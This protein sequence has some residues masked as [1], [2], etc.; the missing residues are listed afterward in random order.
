MRYGVLILAIFIVGVPTPNQKHRSAPPMPDH[1]V[2]ARDTF[3]DFG[4]PFDD[5]ELIFVRP[6]EDGSSIERVRLTPSWNECIDPGKVE[7][8]AASINKSP[9]ALLGATNPCAIPEKELTRELKRRKHGLVFSGAN[10]VLQ[11][12]C[13]DQLRQIK[14]DILDRDI[15]LASPDTPKHTSWTMKLLEQLDQAIGSRVVD[16]P[17]FPLNEKPEGV[18]HPESEPDSPTLQDV[19]KGKFDALFPGTTIKASEVYRAAQLLPPAPIV[20]LVGA[21]DVPPEAFSLPAYPMIA[22][23]TRTEGEVTFDF[24]IDHNGVPTNIRNDIGPTSLKSGV[25]SAIKSWKFP[26]DSAGRQVKVTFEFLLTCKP[27]NHY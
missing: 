24:D 26:K 12:Q 19:S 22:Q 1:F 4:P 18:Q 2:I 14:S 27:S 13:G 8:A 10:V 11:V 23:M 21:L 6:T 25:V 17:I 5:L 3:W 20:R 7:V 15:Y 16:R 9:V